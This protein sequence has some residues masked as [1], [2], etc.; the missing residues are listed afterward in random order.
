MSAHDTTHQNRLAAESS[1]YLLL[2]QHNPVD[3]YPWGPEALA[4]AREENK[5][6]FLSV[7][8][9]TCYWCHVMERESFSSP[10]V[11]ERMNRDFISIKVDREERPDI[12]EIYMAATQ[13]LTGQGGWP[14][15]VFLTPDLKPFYAG[16]YFPPEERY[17]RPSFR[18]VLEGLSDAWHNR[19]QEV[20]MQSEELG[21]AMGRY[22]EQRVQPAAAPPGPDVALRSLETLARRFDREHG[23]FGGAPKFPSPANLYLCLELA[24]ERQPMEVLAGEMLSVTLDRMARGGIYDQ[25]G[26]GFHRY[27]TDREW[28]VPHFEKMLYDN[29]F[30]LEL[31]AREHARTGDAQAARI[32]RET[33]QWLS[34]EM[35]APE[36]AFWSAIDAETHGHEGAYYV[37]TR[38]ELSQVLGEE[39]AAFLAPLL[40]FDGPPF[41]EG[42]HYVL[43]LPERVEEAAARRR[44]VPDDLLREVQALGAKLLEARARRERPLTDDKIL[45]D[46]NGTVIAGLAVAGE[47]LGDPS[48]IDRAAKAARFVLRRMR[49]PDGV[50]LHAWRQGSG[51]IPAY[52]D[53]Y[54]FVVHGLLALHKAQPDERWLRAAVELTEE[55][56]RRL[57]DPQGG[58][59]VA[60]ESPDLLFRSKDVFDGA[61]PAGNAVAILNLLDLFQRTGD[62][63]WRSEARAA[64]QAFAPMIQGSPEG[65]RMMCLAARRFHAETA[66]PRAAWERTAEASG[67]EKLARAAGELVQV[68]LEDLVEAA[69]SDA[70]RRFRLVLEIAPDWHLQANPASEEFLIATEVVAEDGAEIRDLL[71]PPGEPLDA[72][73]AGGE[74][75]SVYSG[76]VEITGQ[77]RGRGKLVVR[78]QPCDEARCL[79]PAEQV[80]AWG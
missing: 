66:E 78:F 56:I 41:F 29:G 7:G 62:D 14:N 18:T 76:H 63:V 3:W 10:E 26:G 40:G 2:H 55:Q 9:S 74:R 24:G 72:G 59:F 11:A 49:A 5:P 79:P 70:W 38:D 61:T 71:Y 17:G 45:S 80:V 53:D 21:S 23:G 12:D 48:L 47:V 4:K 32:V 57:R 37:W 15:S 28:K 36:G 6:I 30:L 73:F 58:F 64:L 75:L 42:D 33:A 22:L 43:H 69:D 77:L 51:R 35:T 31:Y 60:G 67:V 27:A 46:W 16:T 20:E 52:L 1:P 34:R 25:L 39:D 19:R 50:L 13:I 44:T 65:A 54:A 68:R 8:Y